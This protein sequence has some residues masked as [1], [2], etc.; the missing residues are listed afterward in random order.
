MPSY[1]YIEQLSIA[2]I[3]N[4]PCMNKIVLFALILFLL[5]CKS[6]DN[7]VIDENTSLEP[8]STGEIVTHTYYSLAYSENDEQAYWV[9]YHLTPDLINGTQSR[10][11]DFREDPALSTGSATL[12][13]Y[14]GSGY[15]R[16]HLCPAADMTMNQTSM[17]E[18]FFM[19]NMSPQT[20][21]FNRGIWSKLEKQ[22]RDW[23]IQYNGLYIATGGIL[24]ENKGTIGENKVTIPISFYKVIY[25][26][27]N[28]MIAFILP[29]GKST[30]DLSQFVVSVDS[31]E[32][33]TGIDFFSGLD[34]KTEYIL[35]ST[36]DVLLWDW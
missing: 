29:N 36:S 22:I 17:S 1:Q 2:L 32:S 18:S 19:S 16:G 25:S 27:Q 33:I 28:G 26:E 6:Q 8:K 34:D 10:T 31:V 9:F 12:L 3:N 21:G 4:S 5:S 15:D 20:P 14:K 11:D 23:A 7:F 13:D 35:E 30:K 24:K